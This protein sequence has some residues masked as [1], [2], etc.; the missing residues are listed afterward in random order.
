MAET[1]TQSWTREE[2]LALAQ[3]SP[4]CVARH[5]REAWLALFADGGVVEDPV[6]TAPHRRG[7][8]P[9]PL[10]RFY[11]TFIAPNDIAF[12][13]TRDIVVGPNV[14]RDVVI[15]IQAPTG[16]T[17][18]VPTYA[19]Y[20]LIAVDGQPKIA[21][22]AA[23]WELAPMVGQVLGSGFAGLKMMNALGLRMLR[24]QGLSGI[25]GYA[26]GFVGIGDRGKDAVQYFLAALRGGSADAMLALF[27]RRNTGIEVP[28]GS[29]PRHPAEFARSGTELT[30]SAPV[31]AGYVTACR[32]TTPIDGAPFHGIMMFDFDRTSHKIARV[33]FFWDA[34]GSRACEAQPV[35]PPPPI[36][37]QPAE[38]E[39]GPGAA[40]VGEAG[41]AV[42]GPISE[43]DS[44]EGTPDDP[45]I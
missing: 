25:W 26:Q 19:L 4:A 29:A 37:P 5:D 10:E 7:P 6:G 42:N 36:E 39:S 24:L 40:V 32:F 41:Q 14:L 43:H 8:H 17:M 22:L 20:E 1:T 23:H 34:D 30:V 21:R 15:D 11:D 45:S 31:S 13:V 44:P 9:C 12:R 3:S 35:I 27:D 33:R 18:H 38:E 16:L 2:A 28:A